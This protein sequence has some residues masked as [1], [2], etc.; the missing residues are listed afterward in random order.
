MRYPRADPRSALE[1][2][3][4]VVAFAEGQHGEGKAGGYSPRKAA[5]SLPHS[6]AGSARNRA[7]STA[8]RLAIRARAVEWVLVYNLDGMLA[9]HFSHW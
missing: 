5:A 1:C 2:R 4:E 3:S 6:L 8:P 7:H 9:S